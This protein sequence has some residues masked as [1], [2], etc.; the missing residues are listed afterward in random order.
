MVPETAVLVVLAIG[1]VK[2][3]ITIYELDCAGVVAGTAY[4]HIADEDIAICL[5]GIMT[6]MEAD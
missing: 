5:S 3:V 6:A 1:A 4:N 2:N